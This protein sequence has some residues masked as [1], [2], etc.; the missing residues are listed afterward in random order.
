LSAIRLGQEKADQALEL[1]K[2]AGFLH[3]NAICVCLEQYEKQRDKYPA[4]KDYFPQIVAAFRKLAGP[5][6]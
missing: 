3:L 2:N 6:S 5:G 1:D 4:L